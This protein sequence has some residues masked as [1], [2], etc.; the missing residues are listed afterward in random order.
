MA[1]YVV[2]IETTSAC[3][4]GACGSR[5]YAE[6]PS[7]KILCIAWCDANSD[8]QPKSWDVLTGTPDGWQEVR[9]LLLYADCLIAHNAAFE[10]NVL[11]S[12]DGREWAHPL[13]WRDSAML[14][15]ACGRPRALK[16]ACRSLLLPEDKSKDARGVRLLNTFSKRTPQGKL[17][18]PEEKPEEFAELVAYCRQDVVAERALW[19]ILKT[20]ASPRLWEQWRLDTEIEEFGVPIDAE[21]VEGARKLYARVQAEAE[22][23]ALELTEGVPLRSTVGLREWTRA[24]GWALDS[25]S[26]SAIDSAL[27]N[28][29]MCDEAPIVAEFLRLRKMSAGTACKKYDAIASMIASDGK[30]HGILV[31][32]AAHTGRYAG[33]GL[34]PQNLPRGT[35]ERPFLPVIRRVAQEAA[36]TDD[37]ARSERKLDLLA[38]DRA[39]D[40]LA[41]ILRDCIAP[42]SANECLVV[43]DYSAIEARVLAWLSGEKWVEEIFAGDGKIY[44]RTAAAI[45]G[46]AVESVTKH[47]RM[48]GKIATL[49]LGYGGGAGA[50]KRMARAYNVDFDDETALG[51]V[52]AWRKSRPRTIKFWSDLDRLLKRILTNKQSTSQPIGNGIVL[53]GDWAQINGRNVALIGLPSGRRIFYWNPQLVTVGDR[54]EITVE[55]YGATGDKGTIPAEAKGAHSSKLYGGRICENIVQAVAFD[56]L[57][58]AL[59]RLNAKGVNIAFHVHDEIVVVAEKRDAGRVCGLMSICMTTPPSWA[60]GLVLAADPEVMDRYRK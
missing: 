55:M 15:G 4:L 27:Q 18:A 36:K 9:S 41:S 49:A 1:E 58:T 23:R 22:R 35:F 3:D 2:D 42:L 50:L 11:S 6:H 8:E 60:K 31:G 24:K 20:W 43:S 39:N 13:L 21:E 34:Q 59:L 28:I 29:Q 25:F 19:R 14:C 5:V 46:K 7:T 16:D 51:I 48:A 47:E 32:R 10:R 37:L 53:T 44:E 38:G 12:L 26:A 33:R 40:A 30:C 56:L 45:Y 54:A 57:L 52:D 17:Y